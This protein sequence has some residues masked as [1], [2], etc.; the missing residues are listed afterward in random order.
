[1]RIKYKKPWT[2]NP[3]PISYDMNSGSILDF[4]K[5]ETF[6]F[7]I[8]FSLPYTTEELGKVDKYS[9]IVW[10]GND[11]LGIQLIDKKL[12]F[13]FRQAS[14]F[15]VINLEYD[16]GKQKD[17]E[18]LV[19]GNNLNTVIFINKIQTHVI[20][21]A[22]VFNNTSTYNFGGGHGDNIEF[23]INLLSLGTQYLENGNTEVIDPS[24][25][26]VLGHYR[27]DK[28]TEEKSWDYS[29]HFNLINRFYLD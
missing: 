25:T 11:E 4:N 26:N 10:K 15:K 19:T 13:T 7:F 23:D 22:I 27:F 6:Y 14:N 16:F 21:S 8:N 24:L 9:N 28:N 5:S 1:M 17:L 18:V 2:I 12:I 20:D 29:P 3:D